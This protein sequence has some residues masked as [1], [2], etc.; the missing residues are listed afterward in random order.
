ME[1]RVATIEHE[2]LGSDTAEDHSAETAIANGRSVGPVLGWAS[3][4]D[5]QW[6]RWVGIGATAPPFSLRRRRPPDPDPLLLLLLATSHRDGNSDRREA[7][8]K[9]RF[10]MAAMSFT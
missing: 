8:R 9:T 7:E 6:P 5:L 10:L 1:S 4:H 2:G 3:E